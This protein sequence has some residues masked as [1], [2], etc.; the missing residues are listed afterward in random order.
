MT[1]TSAVP[2]A[3]FDVDE[4]LVATKSLLD[5]WDFWATRQGR[6]AGTG[7]QPA[8]PATP[9]TAAAGPPDRSRLNR[10]YYRRYRGTPLSLL[11]AAARDWYALHRRGERAFVTAGLHALARHRALGHEIVLVSGSLRPLVDAVAA[12]LGATAVR[13]AAQTVTDDGLLTG[14]IDRPMIGRAKADAV[15]AHLAER[16]ARASDCH[17]YGDHDSDLPMLRSVGHPVVIGG[18]PAL[19]QEAARL[20][21]TTLPGDTGP[22]PGK[23]VAATGRPPCSA[24]GHRQDPAFLSP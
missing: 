13:C 23:A 19:R 4:T 10:E 5:F 15:E 3:F 12:D 6:P 17:A 22:H 20:G 7:R 14:E 2:V 1:R 21:W 9:S 11:Q 16:G 8:P 18:A 24:P